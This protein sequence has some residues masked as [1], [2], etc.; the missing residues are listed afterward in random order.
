MTSP[1]AINPSKRRKKPVI[2]S[3]MRLWA[4]R[5]MASPTTPAETRMAWMSIPTSRSTTTSARK[6]RR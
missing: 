1:T 6:A 2:T 4:P 3:L 5:P